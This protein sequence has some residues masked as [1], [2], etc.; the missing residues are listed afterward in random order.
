MS[1]K[2]TEVKKAWHNFAFH[3]IRQTK[4]TYVPHPVALS[5]GLNKRS[6]RV[7]F[8]FTLI[9]LASL[10]EDMHGE[11]YLLDDVVDTEDAEG[12]LCQRIADADR[13]EVHLIVVRQRKPRSSYR[14]MLLQYGIDAGDTLCLSLLQ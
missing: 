13:G 8:G 4:T 14:W 3:H 9:I 2:G 10:L 5:T 6:T 11:V 7:P 1:R 12:I